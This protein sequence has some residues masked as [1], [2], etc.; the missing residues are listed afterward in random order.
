MNRR[1]CEIV[2]QNY[3]IEAAYK[4]LLK[5]LFIG[6]ILIGAGNLL[7]KCSSCALDRLFVVN[8]EA[9]S[10]TSNRNKYKDWTG[11]LISMTCRVM[12][13][14]GKFFIIVSMILFPVN[15]TIAS[16]ASPVVYMYA[17]LRKG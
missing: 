1:I 8:K 13:L 12:N 9:V 15:Y 2:V 6:V 3:M 11:K 17:S 7:E 10:P 4:P 14:V 5:E 16:M